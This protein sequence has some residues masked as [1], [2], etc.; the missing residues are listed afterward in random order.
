MWCLRH[1]IITTQ[2]FQISKNPPATDYEKVTALS[3]LITRSNKYIDRYDLQ[4]SP[5]FKKFLYEQKTF[6]QSL[7]P[8][9]FNAQQP[10]ILNYY[11]SPISY[12]FILKETLYS[13]D[14]LL[15]VKLISEN[16]G[17]WE[18]GVVW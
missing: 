12:S 2:N 4:I 13:L 10:I 14:L 3:Q 9:A 1:V 5:S 7:D 11:G 15:Q 18:E 16:C 6:L 17:S 8:E